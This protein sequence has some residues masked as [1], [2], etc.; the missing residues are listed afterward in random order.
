M[1]YLFILIIFL[2]SIQFSVAQDHPDGPYKKFYDTGE[3]KIEGQ[4]ED[5]VKTGRWKKF[6]KNGQISILYSYKNGI[7][8]KENISYYEDGIVKSKT[9]KKGDYYI[10]F[11]YYESGKLKYE[12]RLQS[13]YYRSYFESGSI[14][15]EATYLDNELVGKWKK[16][17]ENGEIEWI[18]NY[19]EGYRQREYKNFYDNGDLKLEGY[20]FKDKIYGEEKRYLPNNVLEWKGNYEGGLLVKTWI[21]FD[22]KGNKIEKIK[23]KK[24][25]PKSIEFQD[26]L[27]PTKIPD[28]VTEHMPVF[29]SCEKALTNSIKKKCAN[30]VVAKFIISNFNK[31]MISKLGLSPGKKQIFVIFKIDKTGQVKDVKAK[32]PHPKL[33]AEAIRII[34]MLPKVKPGTQK[35]IPVTMP[36]SIPIIFNVQ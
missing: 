30:Q 19:E 31:N 21:K 8:N 3:L 1:K 25:I 15:I 22:A 6:Y 27:K 23:F 24:G 13:G 7:R 26:V 32:A 4:Y 18:V 2:L 35:K 34:K 14:D 29:P 11:G 20:N 33:E 9:E 16:H 17:Y 36:F 5:N 12:R 28:G 10:R